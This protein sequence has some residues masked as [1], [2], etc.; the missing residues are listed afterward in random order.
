MKMNRI[1]PRLFVLALA[2]AVSCAVASANEIPAGF[3]S[4]DA[5]GGVATVG[6]F[7]ITNLTGLNS[8]LPD[9]PIST[10]LTFSITSLTV[11]FS[12]GG[13]TILHAADFASDLNGGF[14]GNTA[15][16][17][18]TSPITNAVLVGTFSPITGVNDA[19]LH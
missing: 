9:F 17:L 13:S 6:S 10:P 4:L 3:L 7:D 15:F 18:L 14:L 8:I 2:L 16:N 11:N 1:M 5:Q 12:G 19:C